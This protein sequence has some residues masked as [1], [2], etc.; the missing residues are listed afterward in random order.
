VCGGWVLSG[1]SN[2]IAVLSDL[3]V[4]PQAADVFAV[5]SFCPQH[6]FAPAADDLALLDLITA[7]AAKSA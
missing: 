2:M 1:K 4:G 5:P 3:K 7:L 6:P